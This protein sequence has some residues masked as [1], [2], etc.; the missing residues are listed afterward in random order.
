MTELKGLFDE[1][2]G[3]G[4]IRRAPE[5][6]Q[7]TDR[8][9]G[10]NQYGDNTDFVEGVGA[11]IRYLRHRMLHGRT[12]A[13]RAR[14]SIVTSRQVGALVET[15]LSCVN[16]RDVPR[17]EKRIKPLRPPIF[18]QTGRFY[19]TRVVRIHAYDRSGSAVA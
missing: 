11:A 17:C 4:D 8:A 14:T 12:R 19:A 1:L 9:I 16:F 5:D 15:V 6:D 18:Y 7:E 3:T 2:V 13:R 10:K